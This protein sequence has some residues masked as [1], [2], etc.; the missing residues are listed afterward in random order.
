MLFLFKSILGSFSSC[1]AQLDL[2]GSSAFSIVQNDM[3]GNVA[4]SLF[5]VLFFWMRQISWAIAVEGIKAYFQ[6]EGD[7]DPQQLFLTI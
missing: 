2:L 5:N 1:F 4:V 7:N 3:T 6:R